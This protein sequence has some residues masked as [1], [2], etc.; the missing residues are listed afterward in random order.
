[1][2]GGIVMSEKTEK[3]PILAICYD[4]DK[5]LSPDDM[6]SQGYIQSLQYAVPDF[7]KESHT[8]AED[9]EMDHNL[10][11]MYSM[12]IKSHGKFVCNKNEVRKAGAKVEFFPGVENWFERINECGNQHGV[13]VKHYIISSGLKEMIEGT[14]IADKFDAIYASSFYYDKDGVAVWPAQ[15]INYTNKTQFL[16]RI[17]KGVLDINSSEVNDLVRPENYIV[18]FRNMVYIGDSDTDVPCMK[19]VSSK[20]GY[21]IGVFNPDTKDKSKVLKMLHDGRI[22]YFV[23]ADY[24]EN[25]ALDELIKRIIEKT[26]A[27]E[28]LQMIHVSCLE[29]MKKYEK[30]KSS[31][32]LR[33]ADLINKLEDS[34]SFKMT[35]LAIRQLSE[36][37]KWKDE[38]KDKLLQIGLTN[39]QVKWILGDEDVNHFYENICKN[40]TSENAKKIL[41][42]INELK[43]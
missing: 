35:H 34:S 40:N 41:E 37:S 8:R 25:G 12:A 30:E 16:F 19:L 39:N 15:V 3:K 21:S 17:E 20:G 18:P 29:E 14:A 24:S 9:T 27:N 6:Q 13:I 22:G 31:E 42:K 36:F 11:W 1:M 5:T 4:F 23:G 32:E 33:K 7:W 43:N 10:S 38:Q 26:E 28:R 2:K